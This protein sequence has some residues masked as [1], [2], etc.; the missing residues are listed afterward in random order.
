[1]PDPDD[2]VLEPDPPNRYFDD[3]RPDMLSGRE[4]ALERWTEE[5]PDI[6]DLLDA[7]LRDCVYMSY[8]NAFGKSPEAGIDWCLEQ[9][10]RAD[11]ERSKD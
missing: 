7:Q 11:A 2:E 6:W 10:D 8:V 4:T 5:N 3:G 9:A 1:M